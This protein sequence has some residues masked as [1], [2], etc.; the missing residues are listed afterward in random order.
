MLSA[1]RFVE[2]AGVSAGRV[3]HAGA[4]LPGGGGTP[5]QSRPTRRPAPRTATR[6]HSS[7]DARLLRTV[8]GD[9][10]GTYRGTGEGTMAGLG[11]MVLAAVLAV[12]VHAA[13][14]S[15]ASHES[16]IEA[17]VSQEIRRWPML[18]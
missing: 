4:R 7:R 10:T 6:T 9:R 18:D 15:Q 3:S 5:R 13:P 16:V 14:V 11:V 17:A 2:A 12:Q 1:A 8:S